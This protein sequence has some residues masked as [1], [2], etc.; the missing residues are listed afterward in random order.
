MKKQQN[1]V[2]DFSI[3]SIVL[4]DEIET[5]LYLELQKNILHLLIV[6]FPNIQLNGLSDI[7]YS[8]IVERYFNIAKNILSF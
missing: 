3:S 7:P 4:I 8:G 5:H 2:F 1:R 6:I